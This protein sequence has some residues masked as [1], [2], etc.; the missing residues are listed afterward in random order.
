MDMQM[1]LMSQMG[2]M[3]TMPPGL[4]MGM[5]GMPD[6]KGMKG[7][8]KGMMAGKGQTPW[9]SGAAAANS[10]GSPAWPGIPGLHDALTESFM[11]YASIDPE[12]GSPEKFRDFIRKVSQKI[13]KAAGKYTKDERLTV[14]SQTNTAA[15]L[16]IEEFCDACM[17]SMSQSCWEKDW[18]PKV[19]VTEPLAL[20]CSHILKDT[21]VCTR[22]VTPLMRN[23]VDEGIFKYREE[24]RIEKAFWSA[25]ENAGAL[26]SHKKKAVKNLSTSYDEAFCKANYGQFPTEPAG[27]GLIQ[28]FVF[29]WISDFM[30][31]SYDVLTNG[32][33]NGHA[34][35]VQ[36][37]F[38]TTLFQELCIPENCCVPYDLLS[39]VENMPPAPWSFIAEAVVGM[40]NTG[41]PHKRFKGGGKG[42]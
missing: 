3:G 20:A 29:F 31:R 18:F 8:M 11:P 30:S 32:L 6:M 2:Q 7:M 36:K 10:W 38:I 33:P 13:E 1:Q 41:P 5:Q 17:G 24:E 42:F 12:L 15:K 9:A 35:D 16:I 23:Y 4:G 27:L 37:L 28:D 39:Q 25:V 40:Y 22:L 21:K 34:M 19:D 14:R 26:E